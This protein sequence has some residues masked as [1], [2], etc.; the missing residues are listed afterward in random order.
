MG[1][2]IRKLFGVETDFV[3]QMLWVFSW[4]EYRS[5]ESKIKRQLQVHILA[6][7][8]GH[9]LKKNMVMPWVYMAYTYHI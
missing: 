3:I 2:V 1:F 7:M 8:D 4:V 6:A 5:N 9:H